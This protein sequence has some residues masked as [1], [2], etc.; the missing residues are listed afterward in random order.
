MR[1]ADELLKE[2]IQSEFSHRLNMFFTFR[3]LR[4]EF[5]EIGHCPEPGKNRFSA[6]PQIFAGIK[7]YL[8]DFSAFKRRRSTRTIMAG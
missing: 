7:A 6:V 1:R 3:D 4:G 2:Y 5:A 8:P